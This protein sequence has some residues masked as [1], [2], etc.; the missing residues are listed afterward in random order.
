MLVISCCTL[1]APGTNEVGYDPMV[2]AALGCLHRQRHRHQEEAIRFARS[3]PGS[4]SCP[5]NGDVCCGWLDRP[6]RQ[7]RVLLR[8]RQ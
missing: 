6:Q 5:L 2:A 8:L 3:C 7:P 4:C 1:A